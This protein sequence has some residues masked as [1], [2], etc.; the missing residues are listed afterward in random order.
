VVNL[1]RM[2]LYSLVLVFIMVTSI[3]YSE[4]IMIKGQGNV[5]SVQIDDGSC[6][7][8]KMEVKENKVTLSD[9]K[10]V[11]QGM[12]EYKFWR[13]CG[14]KKWTKYEKTTSLPGSAMRP[15]KHKIYRVPRDKQ[16]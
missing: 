3:A 10:T 16:T 15:S 14:E 6:I 13:P 12:S 7:E 9:G 4:T 5:L 8:F 2:L 11:V 1:R